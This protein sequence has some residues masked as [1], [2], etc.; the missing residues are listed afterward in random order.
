MSHLA[1]REID[2]KESPALPPLRDISPPIEIESV[3][4]ASPSPLAH[5]T[6]VPK[7]KAPVSEEDGVT[8]ENI[9][10][11][12]LPRGSL[13][14]LY[15]EALARCTQETRSEKVTD[16]PSPFSSLK[17]VPPARI[18]RY[19]TQT[20]SPSLH[21]PLFFSRIILRLRARVS[22]LKQPKT[23]DTK[24]FSDA[25]ASFS[26]PKVISVISD[27]TDLDS[28]EVSKPNEIQDTL[29]YSDDVMEIS[30]VD[31]EALEIATG[32]TPM[33]SLDTSSDT[34]VASISPSI[35]VNNMDVNERLVSRSLR[36]VLPSPN[37][38]SP[39]RPEVTILEDTRILHSIQAQRVSTNCRPTSP[40]RENPFA[41]SPDMLRNTPSNSD[42][43]NYQIGTPQEAEVSLLGREN[44]VDQVA[45]IEPIVLKDAQSFVQALRQKFDASK[46]YGI[47]FHI[48]YLCY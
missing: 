20:Q 35:L 18:I 40:D 48:F 39:L 27:D 19:T 41:T 31:S 43:V 2:A 22:R 4:Q 5:N 37:Q 9:G 21:T 34:Q 28:M 17:C 30:A 47:S 45:T 36:S 46:I 29:T 42:T 8:D 44:C 3:F 25:R 23:L 38:E 13:Q 6:P 16:Q 26:N 1:S 15:N 32:T 11:V 12:N 33:P 24:S 14:V 10:K 7:P